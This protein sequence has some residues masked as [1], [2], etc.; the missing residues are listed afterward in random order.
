MVAALVVGGHA[1]VLVGLAV[2]ELLSLDGARLGLGV[3]T[4]I[5]LGGLGGLLLVAIVQSLRGARWTRGFLVFSQLLALVLTFNF[6]DDVWWLP[7]GLGGSALVAL[8]AL[9]SP[10]VAA[11]FEERPAADG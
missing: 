8:G 7:V 4:A 1:A 5:F 9:L 6:R 11:A 2:A 10:A 3:S